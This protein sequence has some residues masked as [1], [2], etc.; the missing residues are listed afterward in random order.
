MEHRTRSAITTPSSPP[1]LQR[2]ANQFFKSVI[3]CESRRIAALLSKSVA[4][5]NVRLLSEDS[6]L[7]EDTR[8]GGSA[9]VSVQPATHRLN[10]MTQSCRPLVDTLACQLPLPFQ[11][12]FRLHEFS[13]SSPHSFP[14][15]SY[16][17]LFHN[18]VVK[19]ARI[20]F[21]YLPCGFWNPHHP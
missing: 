12:W 14:N 6:S 5:G 9:S 13:T 1:P 17:F 8:Q 10:H 2:S 11:A 4:F 16:T 20:R 7:P 15:L 21:L 3:Q 18:R 19:T